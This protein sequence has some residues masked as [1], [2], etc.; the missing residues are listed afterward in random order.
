MFHPY[1]V[2]RRADDAVD[3]PVGNARPPSREIQVRPLRLCT[4]RRWVGTLSFA[5]EECYNPVR[6]LLI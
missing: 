4:H 1:D 5:L 6:K 3:G 2:R